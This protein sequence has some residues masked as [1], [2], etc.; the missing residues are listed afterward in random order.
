MVYE[1]YLNKPFFKKRIK[2]QQ[3]GW[4]RGPLLYSSL[5]IIIWQPLMDKIALVEAFVEVAKSVAGTTEIEIALYPR[6]LSHSP[7]W[8]DP[9]TSIIYQMTQKKSYPPK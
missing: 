5:A 2:G 1:F 3:D 9:V 4:I 8:L 7:L 6:G